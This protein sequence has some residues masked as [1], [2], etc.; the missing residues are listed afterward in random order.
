M[1]T[2]TETVKLPWE[3]WRGEL[4]FFFFP[5]NWHPLGDIEIGPFETIEDARKERA[6]IQRHDQCDDLRGSRLDRVSNPECYP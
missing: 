2:Q 3:I 6:L 5:P 4:G 1:K